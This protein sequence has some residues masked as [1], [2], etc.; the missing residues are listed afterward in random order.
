MTSNIVDTPSPGLG[1]RRL[2]QQGDLRLRRP[3]PARPGRSGDRQ[4]PVG[5][6]EHSAGP[7]RQG[8]G[9]QEHRHGQLGQVPRHQ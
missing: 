7:V 9:G 5:R 8:R 6:Q 4:E 2:P 1:M 3:G